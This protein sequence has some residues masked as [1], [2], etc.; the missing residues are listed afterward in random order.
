LPAI[1]VSNFACILLT[2]SGFVYILTNKPQGT[3]YIGVTADLPRRIHAHREGAT[4]SFTQRYGLGRL[5]YYEGFDDI[6]VAI[7]RE[8]TLKHWP[9]AWKLSLIHDFNPDWNDLYEHLNE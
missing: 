7:Q 2:M 5:V 6:R 4:K 1:A 9:R 8:K 3:L